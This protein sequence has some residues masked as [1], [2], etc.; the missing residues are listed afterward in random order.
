MAGG[1]L[2]P[3]V[4]PPA[5]S[6]LDPVDLAP[7]FNDRVTQIFRNEYR[8]PRSPFVSLAIPKQGLGGWAGSVN[9]GADIDDS[10]LR[11]VAARNGGRIILPSGVPLATPGAAGAR[12]VLFT[13]RWENYPNE[14]VIPL[15]GRGAELYLLMA[16][17][18]GPMQSRI[19]NG[20][21]IVAY[22]DGTSER[23]ALENP[24][25]WWPIE[26]DYFIDDYQFRRP[27]TL[28]ER[29]DL[30]T[31]AVRVL[32]S[33]GF[34][35]KGGKV[36]GGAATVLS[37]PLR[38]EKDLDSLTVRTLANDTVIGLMSATLLRPVPGPVR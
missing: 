35:G 23:L 22:R 16:G 29:V 13:S 30:R 27:G 20:E 32:D 3:L 25:T 2:P 36:P 5:G 26:Q 4:A 15:T 12:N 37:L 1:G 34:K 28:P 9:A 17:S 21:I 7:Y 19:D 33:A 11:T 38:P 10:G 14:A 18:T 8:A 24:T 6:T 31:G